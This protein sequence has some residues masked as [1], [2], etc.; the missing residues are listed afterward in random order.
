MTSDTANEFNALPADWASDPVLVAGLVVD[1]DDEHDDPV[2]R[3]P[4]GRVVDTWREDYPY[5]EKMPRSEYEYLKRPLQIP[6]LGGRRR[7]EKPRLSGPPRSILGLVSR[8]RTRK[9]ATNMTGLACERGPE[10]LDRRR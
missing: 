2:L 3:W 8:E 4:D 5:D 6:D 1:D 10:R 7:V 9:L